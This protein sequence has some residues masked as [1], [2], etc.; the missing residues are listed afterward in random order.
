MKQLLCG[1]GD[2]PPDVRERE[3]SRDKEFALIFSLVS[4]SGGIQP[5]NIKRF[6]ETFATDIG[7]AASANEVYLEWETYTNPYGWQSDV[8]KGYGATTTVNGR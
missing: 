2:L 5:A 7:K 8:P 6:R 1:D 4:R 3:K